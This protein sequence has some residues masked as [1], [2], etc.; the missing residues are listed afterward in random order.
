MTGAQ[1]L[2]FV[3]T[4]GAAFAVPGPAMLLAMRNTLTGGLGTG[5]ATGAGLGLIAA[6]WTLAALTGLSALFALVPWAFGAMKLAGALYLIWISIQ[7]W[8][9]AGAP[10]GEGQTGR[11]RWGRAFVSGMLV[12]LGNPKSVLFAGAVLVVI[13]PAGLSLRDGAL[14]IGAHFMLELLGYALIA[15]TLSHPAARGAYLRAKLWIDRT[16]G[17]VLGA[18]GL[19][20]LLSR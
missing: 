1:L 10:L 19:R 5:I 9:E 8:R 17:A 11:R 15:L 18:L 3:L 16:A 6:C 14:V 12:N 13:F 4:L 2:T 7:L 20:L